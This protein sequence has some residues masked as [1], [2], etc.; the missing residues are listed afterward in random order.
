MEIWMD[1]WMGGW[2]DGVN[3]G[4]CGLCGLQVGDVVLVW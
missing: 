2:V 4:S 3:V 1:G